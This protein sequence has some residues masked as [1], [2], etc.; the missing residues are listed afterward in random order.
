MYIVL[1]FISVSAVFLISLVTDCVF[2]NG[3]S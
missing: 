2:V 3:V 1:Y